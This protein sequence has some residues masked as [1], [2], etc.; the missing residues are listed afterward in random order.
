MTVDI[1]RNRFS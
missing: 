1:R